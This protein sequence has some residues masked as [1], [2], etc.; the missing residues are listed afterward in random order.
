MI[1]LKLLAAVAA[2]ALSWPVDA[3][4]FR[5]EWRRDAL[6]LSIVLLLALGAWVIQ[7]CD[8]RRVLRALLIA[9]VATLARR[10]HR[11]PR[12]GFGR[13]VVSIRAG[14]FP[15]L[16]DLV[17][18]TYAMSHSSADGSSAL[19]FGVIMAMQV[20]FDYGAPLSAFGFCRCSQGHHTRREH[21][22]SNCQNQ[23]AHGKFSVNSL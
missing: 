18:P 14:G 21:D 10:R 23:S 19:S 13:N 11:R 15:A 7:K 16:D 2:R 4:A 8:L 20:C 12:A 3:A 1:R 6:A 22:R 9:T 5:G 17:M